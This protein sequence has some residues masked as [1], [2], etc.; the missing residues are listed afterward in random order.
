MLQKKLQAM[1]KGLIRADFLN[2]L[3][4]KRMMRN[5]H[6]RAFANGLTHD[7]VADIEGHEHAADFTR[8]AA[9]QKSRIIPVFC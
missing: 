6:L 5:N 7:K 8:G 3:K 1:A 9:D 4:Q 2:G